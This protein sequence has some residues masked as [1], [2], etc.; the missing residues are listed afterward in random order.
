MTSWGVYVMLQN[1]VE[2]LIPT[3][4]LLRHGFKFNK[5][6]NLYEAKRKKGEKF[7]HTL[8]LGSPIKVRLVQ[9]SE[10]ERKLTFSM[11]YQ[12]YNGLQ[13]EHRG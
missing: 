4:N 7:A 1:T 6:K 5:E 12:L 3:N 11:I 8:Q 13:M 10:D 2:G 9:V